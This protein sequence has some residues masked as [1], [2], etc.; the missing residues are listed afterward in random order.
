MTGAVHSANAP[1]ERPALPTLFVSHGAPTLALD[2]G[3]AHRFLTGLGARLGRPRAVLV[4]SAH[5]EAEDVRVMAT[6]EPAT[7][8]DFFGFPAP[9][10]DLRYPAHGAVDVADLSADLLRR[11]G[12]PTVL[13]PTRGYDHGAWLPL[14]L[15][16]PEADIPVLQLSINPNRPPA[17][18]WRLGRALRAL[19]FAGVLIVGSGSM[20]HNL[21]DFRQQRQDVNCPT[22]PCAEAF[23]AWFET[24]LT[25]GDVEALLAYRERAPHALRAHPTDEHLLPLYVALGAAGMGW[26]AERLHHSFMYGAIAM[27][28]YLF[29]SGPAGELAAPDDFNA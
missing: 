19:C 5:W 29:Q 3:P 22:E 16:Y 23:T 15:M 2:D 4:V 6:R 14:R 24:H 7:V 17:Y 21:Q 1:A 20:T 10:Y 9:L 8:H 13:D 25:T 28:S 26:S 18:H 11:A 27:D 12:Y